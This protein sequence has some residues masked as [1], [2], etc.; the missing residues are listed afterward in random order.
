MLTMDHKE[1]ARNWM[2]IE[3]NL[4]KFLFYI[5]NMDECRDILLQCNILYSQLHHKYEKKTLGCTLT[6]IRKNLNLQLSP[7]L[8]MAKSAKVQCSRSLR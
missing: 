6:S 8:E 7:K 4:E 1:E 5:H 2:K 3:S